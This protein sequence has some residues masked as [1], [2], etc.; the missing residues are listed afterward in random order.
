MRVTFLLEA[1]FMLVILLGMNLISLTF[2][3]IV[4]LSF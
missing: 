1:L 4:E 3:V 2:L